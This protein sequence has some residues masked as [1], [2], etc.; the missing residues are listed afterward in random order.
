[1][2]GSQTFLTI[3]IIFAFTEVVLR[4]KIFEEDDDVVDAVGGSDMSDV[5]VV[6]GRHQQPA[7]NE[8][9]DSRLGRRAGLRPGPAIT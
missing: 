1:L 8:A 6:G 3:S 5:D 4:A 7:S 9:E 2:S